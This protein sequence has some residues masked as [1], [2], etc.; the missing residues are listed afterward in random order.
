VRN[1]SIQ[2]KALTLA[3]DLML[4]EMT[5]AEEEFLATQPNSGPGH[6]ASRA[7]A[8]ILYLDSTVA[9][10]DTAFLAALERLSAAVTTFR[11]VNPGAI[12]A[13]EVILYQNGQPE[14]VVLTNMYGSP[15]ILSWAYPARPCSFDREMADTI[16]EL[17]PSVAVARQDSSLSVAFGRFLDLGNPRDR[18]AALIDAWIGLESFYAPPGLKEDLVRTIAN[19]MSLYLANRR[20]ER[21]DIYK[22]VEASYGVRSLIV[23]GHRRSGEFKSE[24]KYRATMD[25]LDDFISEAEEWLRQ[26]LLKEVVLIAK[27]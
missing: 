13:F 8:S 20:A 16:V 27:A 15:G 9:L 17:F 6:P 11:L 5:S 14:T 26:T 19:G 7:N 10:V 1:V 4:R 24:A 2:G 25:N 23:H 3:P 21:D 18:E 12:A 22:S